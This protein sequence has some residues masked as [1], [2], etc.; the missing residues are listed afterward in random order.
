MEIKWTPALKI[1]HAVIDNQHIELFSL[2]D[3]FVEGCAKERGKVSVVELYQSLKDYVEKHFRDEEALMASSGY[4]GLEKQKREHQKFQR[5]VSELGS[6]ISRQ[7]VTLIELVQ[8]N[9]LLVNL[10]VNHVQDVDQKFGEYLRKTG[11]EE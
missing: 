6:T 8:M 7:G 10:L 4:P 11:G 2:F 9:K 3:E 1:G 5:Q